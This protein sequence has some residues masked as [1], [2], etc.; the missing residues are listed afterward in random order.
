MEIIC[1]IKEEYYIFDIVAVVA[2][3]S[4]IKLYIGHESCWM[5]GPYHNSIAV[6]NG[7]QSMCDCKDSAIFKPFANC[8][9]DDTVSSVIKSEGYLKLSW[10][11]T[12]VLFCKNN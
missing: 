5:Y 3:K 9:L 6:H 8:S 2:S 12:M 10:T 11:S 1:Q 4:A 7:I